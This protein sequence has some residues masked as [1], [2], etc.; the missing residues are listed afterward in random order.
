MGIFSSLSLIAQQR[1]GA[2]LGFPEGRANCGIYCI[3][4]ARG[5]GAQTP[6][7]VA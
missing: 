2:D 3:S 5:L 7:T 6:E 4:E 1:A